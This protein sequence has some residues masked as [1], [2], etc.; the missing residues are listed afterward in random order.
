MAEN[1]FGNGILTLLAGHLTSFM[2]G[3][4][5]PCSMFISFLGEPVVA[6]HA[7]GRLAGC[8]FTVARATRE[9]RQLRVS[10]DVGRR[11]EPETAEG[12]MKMLLLLL[13]LL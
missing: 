12:A 6:P 8:T 3:R 11:A 4:G 7:A 2:A 1:K 9:T 10:S 13:L 5:P